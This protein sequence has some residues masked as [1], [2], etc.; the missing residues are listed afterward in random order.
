M[1]MKSFPQ[2]AK[3]LLL[4]FSV[5]SPTLFTSHFLTVKIYFMCSALH[6]VAMQSENLI[7]LFNV[8]PISEIISALLLDFMRIL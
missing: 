2:N 6:V 3:T 7:F 4:F 1:T 5:D 8:F